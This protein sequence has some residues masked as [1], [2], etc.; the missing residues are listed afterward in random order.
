MLSGV[1]E[2]FQAAKARLNTLKNDPDN[3]VKLK[4]YAFF[5]Q[6]TEGK[7]NKPKPGMMDFVGKAKWDAWNNLGGMSQDDAKS[8]YT[9]IVQDLAAE[10]GPMETAAAASDS[11]ST[12]TTLEVTRQGGA[13]VIKLNRPKKFNAL[14]N[15]TYDEWVRALEEAAKDPT[16]RCAVVTGAGDYFC[17]GNDLTNFTPKEGMSVPEMAQA[18]H[19]LLLRFVAAFIDFPKPLIAAVNGPAVG[20]SVTTLGL[21]DAVFAADHASFHTPFSNLGQTPEGCSSFTFPMIM[22]IS[23]ANALIMFNQKITAQEAKDC[24]LVTK[25]LPRDSFQAEMKTIIDNYA[26]LPPETMV[27]A[28]SL[29]RANMN[30]KLHETNKAECARLMERWTSQE[31]MQA[32]MAFFQ[33]KKPKL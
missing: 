10:E 33:R 12:Y 9:K 28:K 8:A 24:G 31:C 15:V 23:Q 17:S 32:I 26:N 16:V 6:A 29:I 19:D 14:T 30:A 5:K 2:D 25:V 3:M 13:F 22:G 27:Y 21:Y 11:G 4:I 7:C 18:A 20:I 1:N